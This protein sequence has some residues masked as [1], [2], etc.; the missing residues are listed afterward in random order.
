MEVIFV[1]DKVKAKGT[2]ELTQLFA[3]STSGKIEESDVEKSLIQY[4]VGD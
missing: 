4:L 3:S 1:S 2:L